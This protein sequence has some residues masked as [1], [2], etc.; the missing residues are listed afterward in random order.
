MKIPARPKGLGY[1]PITKC[2]E[3]PW[4]DPKNPKMDF[5][6]LYLNQK[7]R[8][9][10]DEPMEI[11]A[12][13][14]AGEVTLKWGFRDEDPARWTKARIARQSIFDEN[15]W[16][17]HLPS[18]GV[19]DVEVLSPTAEF[20]VVKTPNPK[21]FPCRLYSPTE[22]RT[23][24]RGAGTMRET[25]TRIVRTIFDKTNEPDSELVVGE[26]IT[27]PGK[28]SSYPPHHHPQP[29]I[30]HYRFLPEQGFGFSMLGP[31]AVQI[32]QGDTILIMNDISHSQVA[33]PG[34]AMYYLWAIRHLKNNPYGTPTF[35]LEHVWVMDPSNQ[36][37][38]WPPEP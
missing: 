6:I 38:I 10:M 2:K 11:A 16:C 9:I 36:K 18:P 4:D 1:V 21:I 28:W 7:D 33:A 23:E 5:G 37:K 34:Y 27:L 25:S 35:E 32:H 20:C 19:L 31:E 8:I 3:T 15:P 12:V 26:V 29:E 30:Y 22:C 14:M 13:L 17:L 24:H